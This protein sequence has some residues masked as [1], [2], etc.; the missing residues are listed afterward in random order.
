MKR[1]QIIFLIVVFFIGG[2]SCKKGNEPV[3]YFPNQIG[4][5]WNY[6]GFDSVSNA[7]ETLKVSIIGGKIINGVK[8]N[9]WILTYPNHTDTVIVSEKNDTLIFMGYTFTRRMYIIPFSLNQSWDELESSINQSKVVSIENV[10]AAA[11]Y[12]NECYVIERT[13]FSFNY[14]LYE[15]IYF[16]P[17]VGIVKIYT[18]E[19]SL[20]PYQIHTWELKNYSF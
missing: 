18:K 8:S 6:N 2:F 10:V 11:G 4:Y 20:G 15:T 5:N 19:R 16:K 17:Y 3:D 7:S 14:A 1:I 12:F 13:I 9:V